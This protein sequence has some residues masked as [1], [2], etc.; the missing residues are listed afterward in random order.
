MGAAGVG[1]E[2]DAGPVAFPLFAP[3]DDAAAGGAGFGGVGIGGGLGFGFAV[4]HG[5][6]TLKVQ[7]RQPEEGGRCGRSRK[8]LILM[9]D[10]ECDD[11]S[12]G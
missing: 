6:I 12:S 10:Y 5:A 8:F 11:V 4:G 3:G 7:M 9:D 1:A 2:L